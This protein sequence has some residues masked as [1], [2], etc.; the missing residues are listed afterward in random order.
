MIRRELDRLRFVVRDLAILT[1]TLPASLAACDETIAAVPYEAGAPDAGALVDA[2]ITTPPVDAAADA[3]PDVATSACDPQPYDAG[4][5]ADAAIDFC[6]NLVTLPC[7]LPADV[8]PRDGCFLTLNDCD[9]FCKTAFFN[10]RAWDDSCSDGGI[11]DGGG[12]FT[13]DCATCL[14][15]PG[16]R[17]RGLDESAAL[18]RADAS[19]GALFAAMARLEEA[20]IAA[21]RFLARDLTR[22]G[23]PR[24]L[25]RAARAAARDEKRH[26][27]V[28]TRLARRRGVVAPRARVAARRPA[29]LDLAALALENAVEGCVNE[30][31]GAL[32]AAHHAT[33]AR[34]E[35]VRVALAR[36]AND[37]LR[38]AALA[39]AIARW[40]EPQLDDLTRA[41]VERAR[42]DAARALGDE[43]A[44]GLAVDRAAGIPSAPAQ[45]ALARALFASL[46]AA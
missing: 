10:C 25:V 44:I 15:G 33:H 3:G 11:R 41:R 9:R 45:R 19:G 39:W 36:I 27:R 8:V 40:A 18:V 26:T 23:A 29:P 24:E 1:A 35:D 7:G 28:T 21:F 30:T 32:L 17:P 6:S 4:P 31:F 42:R 43:A 34:D 37:E 12:P 13:I 2:T 14:N 16:R 20:S 5:D 38:H 46:E 22:L